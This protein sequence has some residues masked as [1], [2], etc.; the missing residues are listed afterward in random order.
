M[1]LPNEF[2]NDDVKVRTLAACLDVLIRMDPE[3]VRV[4]GLQQ[5]TDDE[6]DCV[7]HATSIVLWGA[8]A[9]DWPAEVHT[10]LARDAD[11]KGQ[12]RS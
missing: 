11:R 9:N 3:A 4:H 10:L 5:C 7:V 12:Q 2:K 6:F 1:D 8:D